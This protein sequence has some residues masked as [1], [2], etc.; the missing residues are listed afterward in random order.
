[1]LNG[2]HHID[3]LTARG[4]ASVWQG[5]H[6]RNDAGS[7]RPHHSTRAEIQELA[8]RERTRVISARILALDAS[9]KSGIYAECHMT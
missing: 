1:V 3:L 7:A 6:R 4:Q 8:Y 5:L 9:A 2:M